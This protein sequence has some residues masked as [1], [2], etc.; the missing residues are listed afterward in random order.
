MEVKAEAVF[1]AAADAA[2]RTLFSAEEEA[3]DTLF[4]PGY[5]DNLKMANEAKARNNSPVAGEP[6]LKNFI[7]HTMTNRAAPYKR[8]K[9]GLVSESTKNLIK[10]NSGLM[11]KIL[12]STKTA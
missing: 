11:F 9:I 1:E 2:G 8:I 6:E 12:I 4:S 7:D 5:T 3:G 10:T